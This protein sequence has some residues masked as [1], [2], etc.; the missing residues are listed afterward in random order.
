[1]LPEMREDG[2]IAYSSMARQN[3]QE[4][5]SSEE[6]DYAS[7]DCCSVFAPVRERSER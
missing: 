6:L 5:E 3:Q 1:M 2:Q 7:T 4:E